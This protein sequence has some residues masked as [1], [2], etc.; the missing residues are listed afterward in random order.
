MPQKDERTGSG[1]WAFWSSLPGILTG[2]AAVIAAAGT[3]AALFAGGDGTQASAP[4]A[5][6][7]A[8]PTFAPGPGATRA[9]AAT[10]AGS[11]A[12]GW[13]PWRPVPA[14]TT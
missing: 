13:A 10:S 1:F 6:A 9:S 12:T 8:E 4:G 5:T 11:R 14:P 3:L 2:I 7:G